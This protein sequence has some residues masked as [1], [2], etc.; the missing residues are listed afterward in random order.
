MDSSSPT[1]ITSRKRIYPLPEPLPSTTPSMKR[2]SPPPEPQP[3]S[4]KKSP[5]QTPLLRLLSLSPP[6]WNPPPTMKWTLVAG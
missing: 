3:L 4:N 1:A 6:I 2:T 5:V